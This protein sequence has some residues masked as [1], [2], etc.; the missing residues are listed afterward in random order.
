MY[1]LYRHHLQRYLPLLLPN[2]IHCLIYQHGSFGRDPVRPRMSLDALP[3]SLAYPCAVLLS[4]PAE[5]SELDVVVVV[6]VV[7]DGID[8]DLIYVEY[9]VLIC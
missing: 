7:V 4:V 2:R 6:V 1:C 5:R 3:L 9:M 8:D